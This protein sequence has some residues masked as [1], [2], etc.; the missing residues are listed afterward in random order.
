MLPR[1]PNYL[2]TQLAEEA[3]WCTLI[4]DGFHLPDEVLKVAM[5]V[6]GRQ[7]LLV[8]DA[9]A[10][11]GLAPGSYDTPVG[12]RVV[13]TPAGRLHLAGE[14]GLLAGS[15]QMLLRHIARLS[16]AGL[17]SLPDAWDMASVQ[18][19]GFMAPACGRGPGRRS[20]GGSGADPPHWRRRCRA[21]ANG[22]VPG[23]RLGVPPGVSV[24][25]AE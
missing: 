1:H 2:W 20:A 7:A 5:K 3:L 6:K 23:R 17:A 13:L 15:A 11:A 10:L 18:P 22:A 16:A 8:S 25:A 9:V 24:A 4:A 21:C 14:P 12:G 19:A